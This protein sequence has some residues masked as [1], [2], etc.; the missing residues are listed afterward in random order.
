MNKLPI[1]P[2]TNAPADHSQLIYYIHLS[3]GFCTCLDV[4]ASRILMRVQLRWRNSGS[5][6]HSMKFVY[7]MANR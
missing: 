6:N 2:L 1:P 7:C 5:P 4:A 3:M